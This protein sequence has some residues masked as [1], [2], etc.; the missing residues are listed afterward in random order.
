MHKN[1]IKQ[2]EC[3]AITNIGD[4]SAAVTRTIAKDK[5]VVGTVVE[6]SCPAPSKLSDSRLSVST[7][8]GDG[9][10]STSTPYCVPGK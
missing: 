10:W 1:L 2:T 5:F 9:N 3:P 6:F 7:C 4:V 8:G